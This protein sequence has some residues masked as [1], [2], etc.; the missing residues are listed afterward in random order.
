MLGNAVQK[1]IQV[2]EARRR[3][4]A[5]EAEAAAAEATEGGQGKKRKRDINS[6][7]GGITEE[8]AP[9]R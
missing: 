4:A 1:G 2:K 7:E 8:P 5:V 9:K 6:S 3:L